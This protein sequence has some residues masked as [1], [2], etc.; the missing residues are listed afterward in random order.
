MGTEQQLL[1]PG[2]LQGGDPHWRGD[3]KG[4]IEK[5]D[6]IKDLGFTAIW[7]TPPVENR[8]GLDYHGYHAYDFIGSIPGWSRRGRATGSSSR[9]P[10]PRGS[11]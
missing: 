11:R 8:S 3:F 9:P 10:T 5:L 4:L 1:Q 6:Y 7:V 2:S